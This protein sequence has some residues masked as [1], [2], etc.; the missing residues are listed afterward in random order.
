MGHAQAKRINRNNPLCARPPTH[1]TSQR[2]GKRRRR[3][4]PLQARNP[5]V[6]RVAAASSTGS[7]PGA[8]FNKVRPHAVVKEHTPP[9]VNKERRRLGARHKPHIGMHTA[10]KNNPLLFLFFAALP[11][12]L[13]AKARARFA[14]SF[15]TEAEGRKH[16]LAATRGKLAHPH[17]GQLNVPCHA[18]YM[19]GG[20]GGGVVERL[21]VRTKQSSLSSPPPFLHQPNGSRKPPPPSLHSPLFLL[22]LTLCAHTTPPPTHTH[23]RTLLRQQPRRIRYVCLGFKWVEGRGGRG[24]VDEG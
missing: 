7:P 16:R 23:A 5:G 12:P 9:A 14:T 22:I 11:G 1:K 10:S 2:G 19:N 20:G 15:A 13:L 6:V 18:F 21:A 3:R 4:C 8:E 17:R 24:R